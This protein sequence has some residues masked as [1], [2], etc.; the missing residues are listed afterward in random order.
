M[1][2]I[3]RQFKAGEKS[4]GMWLNMSDTQVIE[5][6]TSAGFDWICIDLQHGLAETGDLKTH[7]PCPGR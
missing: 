6:I 2:K 7:H 1:N 5:I 3:I 4:H